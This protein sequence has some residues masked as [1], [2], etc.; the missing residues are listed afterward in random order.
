[1]LEEEGNI[2][3]EIGFTRSNLVRNAVCHHDLKNYNSFSAA[4]VKV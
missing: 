1:M 3:R 2:S 4:G